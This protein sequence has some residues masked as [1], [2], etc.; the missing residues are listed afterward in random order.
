MIVNAGGDKVE[1][2]F[3]RRFAP[4]IDVLSDTARSIVRRQIREIV[5]AIDGPI[6]SRA[7]EVSELGTMPGF[8]S[9]EAALAGFF[10]EGFIKVRKEKYGD[11]VQMED[12][13]VGDRAI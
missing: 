12:G 2:A 11:P 13:I 3:L 5:T 6:I 4:D 7:K 10:F 1:V 9:Q 8:G